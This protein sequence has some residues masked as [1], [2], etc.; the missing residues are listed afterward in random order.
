MDFGIVLIECKFHTPR[1]FAS[2]RK[3]RTSHVK[4]VKAT[5]SLSADD[6]VSIDCILL[7]QLTNPLLRNVVDQVFGVNQILHN[8]CKLH[9]CGGRLTD[10]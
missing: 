2:C 10:A 4:S 6:R 8:S 1:P 5:Y 7:F 9:T 3:Y